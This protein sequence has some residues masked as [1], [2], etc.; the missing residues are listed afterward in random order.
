MTYASN[1]DA[2][3][4]E[5]FG[6]SACAFREDA[7]N[8]KTHK[9]QSFDT[10]CYHSVAINYAYQACAGSGVG[11]EGSER[12]LALLFIY[13]E[14]VANYEEDVYAELS[15]NMS[16]AIMQ[17][18]LA[19]RHEYDESILLQVLCDSRRRNVGRPESRAILDVG[20]SLMHVWKYCSVEA[21]TDAIWLSGG[22]WTRIS[23]I[24]TAV[25]GMLCDRRNGVWPD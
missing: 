10:Q 14:I 16:C 6:L 23:A 9:R 4:D 20:E 22:P 5:I 2:L 1:A 19:A 21:S 3:I 18:W 11:D 25:S 17:L 13:V 8:W 12:M 15:V 7:S 24:Y